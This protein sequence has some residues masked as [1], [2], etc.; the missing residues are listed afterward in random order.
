MPSVAARLSNHIK[1]TVTG[2]MWHGAALDELLKDV[3]HE[4][5][6]ARP[7]AGAHTIWEIVVHVTA[8]TEIA[9]ARIHG[10]RTADA[11]P[12]EDWPPVGATGA[13]AWRTALERLRDGH[14][15]L[16]TDVRRLDEQTI[17]A[18]VPGLEYTVSNLLHGVIEHGTYHGGQ[19]ALLKRALER[20]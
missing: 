14:R 11:T 10:E 17:D 19:I 2:P 15:A 1:R 8:W 5:A 3:T 4:Q 20:S 13:D 9:R 7:I 18:K 6:A 16:A 12:A